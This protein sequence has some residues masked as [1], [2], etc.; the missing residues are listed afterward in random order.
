M[1]KSYRPEYY[2]ATIQIRPKNKEVLDFVITQIEKANR[3]DVFISGV[4]EK[5]FGVDLKIS[6][7]KFARDLGKKLKKRFDGELKITKSLF[8]RHKQTGKILYRAT[9]CFRI[10]QEDL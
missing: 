3:E 10:K 9:I 2:E 4:E 7:Q 5:K 8:K 1:P 6:S